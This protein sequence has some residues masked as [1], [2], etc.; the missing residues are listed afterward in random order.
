MEAPSRITRDYAAPSSH[1]HYQPDLQQTYHDPE[2]VQAVVG[3]VLEELEP[4][5][6]SVGS[7][8][9][10][11]PE[12]ETESTAIALSLLSQFVTDW[13]SDIPSWSFPEPDE[14]SELIA[15]YLERVAK[16]ADG[17]AKAKVL[18]EELL[19]RRVVRLSTRSYEVEQLLSN[20]AV[21]E[22]EGHLLS[23]Q[24]GDYAA[25]LHQEILELGEPYRKELLAELKQV[26]TL[27]VLVYGLSN[28]SL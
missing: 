7:S 5:L 11:K 26:T 27:H 14:L 28:F 25:Q 15:N 19:K 10:D 13:L 3:I 8:S 9:S 20:S 1:E 23:K 18:Q 22:E 6:L 24:C 12:R 21:G 16:A 17:P 2:V 4:R